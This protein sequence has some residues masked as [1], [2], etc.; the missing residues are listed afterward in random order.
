MVGN[1]VANG[2]N[3]NRGERMIAR[4][5]SAAEELAMRIS[6]LHEFMATA[7][8]STLVAQLSEVV[9]QQIEFQDNVSHE[10]SS[11]ETVPRESS[12]PGVIVPGAISSATRSS[13]V[14]VTRRFPSGR[15]R[16]T[17]HGA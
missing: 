17:S 1:V 14:P 11:Q 13:E 15:C 10:H 8:G 3:M 6:E 2:L 16:S 12:S 4:V 7:Q 9:P 5:E